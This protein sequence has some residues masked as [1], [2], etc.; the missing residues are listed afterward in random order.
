MPIVSPQA[1]ACALLRAGATPEEANTILRVVPGESSW[2]TDAVNPSSGACGIFQIYPRETGCDQLDTAAP[3]ALRKLRSQG[4]GAWSAADSG[5]WSQA[6]QQALAGDCSGPTT[7]AS[8]GTAGPLGILSSVQR[9]VSS[10][11]AGGEVLVGMGLLVLG[12]AVLVAQTR[13]GGELAR[14]ASRGLKLAGM[15]ALAPK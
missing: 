10:L 2:N 12:A 4:R 13:T 8:S 15:A 9:L 3:I 6:V 14:Q 1:V 5:D 7:A 11:L